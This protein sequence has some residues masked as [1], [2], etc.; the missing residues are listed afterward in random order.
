MRSNQLT[1]KIETWCL[2]DSY[3]NFCIL[4]CALGTNDII[5]Y[6]CFKYFINC[7]E[8]PNAVC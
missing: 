6:N 2:S 5:I 8:F 7:S 1:P 3:S 4:L